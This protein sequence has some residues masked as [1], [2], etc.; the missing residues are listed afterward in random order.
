[1]NK[2]RMIRMLTMARKAMVETDLAVPGVSEGNQN[3]VGQ[4]ILAS[5]IEGSGESISMSLD[6][7]DGL[8]MEIS[9]IAKAISDHS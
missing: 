1:M 2:Q 6:K 5:A 4:L 3:L 7:L 9:E 8:T